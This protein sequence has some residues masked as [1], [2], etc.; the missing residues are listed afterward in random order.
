MQQHPEEWS[1]AEMASQTWSICISALGM[2]LV[3]YG[4]ESNLPEP[5]H[6]VAV[7]IDVDDVSLLHV[8]GVVHAPP[9]GLP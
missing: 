7:V 4:G 6:V 2:G 1:L 5:P 9:N 8:C 3:D